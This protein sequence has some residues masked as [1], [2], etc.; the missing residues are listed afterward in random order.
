MLAPL[1]LTILPLRGSMKDSA[2]RTPPTGST[3]PTQSY[4]TR[5]AHNNSYRIYWGLTSCTDLSLDPNW[6]RLWAQRSPSWVPAWDNRSVWAEADGWW[7]RHAPL[8]VGRPVQSQG[9]LSQPVWAL[10]LPF[11]GRPWELRAA[12]SGPVWGPWGGCWSEAAL[13]GRRSGKGWKEVEDC[14]TSCCHLG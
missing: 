14:P 12:L 1:T 4:R 8:Q 10:G 13:S 3:A 7:G 9:G 6:P 5:L 2:S 11:L